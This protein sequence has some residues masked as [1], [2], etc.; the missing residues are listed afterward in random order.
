[1]AFRPA[2][3]RKIAVEDNP[4]TARALM[5][6]HLREEGKQIAELANIWN[7]RVVSVY[8]IM[9]RKSALS[10]QYIDAFVDYLKLDTFDATELRLQGAREAGWKLTVKQVASLGTT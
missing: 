8:H 7:I 1:M 2:T 6:R 9:Y 5:R 3:G 4:K 10:P